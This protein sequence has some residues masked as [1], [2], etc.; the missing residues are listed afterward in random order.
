MTHPFAMAQLATAVSRPEV[1]AETLVRATLLVATAVNDES[2]TAWCRWELNGY[3]GGPGCDIP[4][5]RIATAV[6]MVTNAMGE[7]VPAQFRDPAI[8]KQL[9]RCTIF[10]SLA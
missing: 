3:P 4:A 2:M 7:D 10:Q 6:L 5:Y 1:S 9:S 8:M